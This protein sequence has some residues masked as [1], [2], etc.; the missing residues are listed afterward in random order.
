VALAVLEK[1]IFKD[2]ASFCGFSCLE[3]IWNFGTIR[4]NLKEANPRYIPAKN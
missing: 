4:T 2:L 3:N 1:K